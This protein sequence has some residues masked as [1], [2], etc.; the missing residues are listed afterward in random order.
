MNVK[1]YQ[2]TDFRKYLQEYYKSKKAADTKFSF[3]Q[4]S[5]KAGLKSPNFLKLVMEGDRNL[6][7]SGIEKFSKA[8][9]HTENQK[10]FFFHLVQMNQSE[11]DHEIEEHYL[12]MNKIIPYAN[13]E[14]LGLE[15]HRYLS[16][17]LYPVLR[18]M[19]ELSEFNEDVYWIARRLRFQSNIPQIRSAIRFLLDE[20]FIQRDKNGKLQVKEKI[21]NTPDEI[22]SMA[23]RNYHRQ[24]LHQAEESLN[25]IPISERE[26]QALTFNIPEKSLPQLKAKIKAFMEEIH[27]WA[28]D[29]ATQ[30]PT[31]LVTQLN[32]QFYP[33]TQKIGD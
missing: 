15:S 8:L 30:N 14:C 32:L 31:Q 16:H 19:V 6:S 20:G 25:K 2:Y 17:W 4:F 21:L 1:L 12:K 29:E 26:I 11:H 9:G 27:H 24:M 28:V 5:K 18:E 10:K 23:Y 3:R 7:A 22:A 13:K 33:H